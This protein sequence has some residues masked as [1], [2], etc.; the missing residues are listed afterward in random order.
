MA[1][2]REQAAAASKAKAKAE[3]EE[4][5]R[6]NAAMREKLDNVQALVDDD[7]SDEAAGQARDEFKGAGN[8]STPEK[9]KGF[10]G[11]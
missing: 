9:K 8:A 2:A 3:K 11:W 5:E 7:I 1:A 4:R 6:Q 10:F